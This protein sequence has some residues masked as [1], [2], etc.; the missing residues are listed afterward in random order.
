MTVLSFD[1]QG[2]DVVYD[3]TE[4]RLEKA[5]IEDAVGKSYPDVTDHEVLKIVEPEPSLS[6]EP[7][8]IA[9]IVE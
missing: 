7:R 4:F 1:E 3:G 2:V 6:G 9:E 5:L 8:Q